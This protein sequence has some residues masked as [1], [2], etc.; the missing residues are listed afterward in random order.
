MQ[1]PCPAVFAVGL[2]V[3][4]TSPGSEVQ[5][6]SRGIAIITDLSLSTDLPEQNAW[7]V[8]LLLMIVPKGV[9]LAR[10]RQQRQCRDG[11]LLESYNGRVGVRPETQLLLL[12]VSVLLLIPEPVLRTLRTGWALYTDCIVCRR[13]HSLG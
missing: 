13:A 7:M 10:K 6:V 12:T 4:S 5:A 11:E 1:T 2:V 9:W 8:G 3:Q